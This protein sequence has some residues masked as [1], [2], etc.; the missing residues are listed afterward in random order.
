MG[1]QAIQQ[2]L[3]AHRRNSAYE[4]LQALPGQRVG[5]TTSSSV[6]EQLD[7]L[8][9]ACHRRPLAHRYRVLV[10]DGEQLL[11][12]HRA[13]LAGTQIRPD[14]SWTSTRP[15]TGEKSTSYGAFCL[16]GSL[17]APCAVSHRWR[18][19]RAGRVVRRPVLVVLLSFASMRRRTPLLLAVAA[20]GAW[21]GTAFAQPSAQF[22]TGHAEPDVVSMWWSV[23]GPVD[24]VRAWRQ[25]AGD[26]EDAPWVLVADTLMLNGSTAY[27]EDRDVQAG[28]RYDY[29]LGLV[30]EGVEHFSASVRMFLPQHAAA[31]AVRTVELVPDGLAIEWVTA[32]LG[33]VAVERRR[34][35]ALEWERLGNA[36]PVTSIVRWTDD[37]PTPGDSVEYQLVASGA[38]YGRH[39]FRVPEPRV[40]NVVL[41]A[42][43]RSVR[44]VFQALGKCADAVLERR[45][46]G[47]SE[48]ISVGYRTL[49][50]QLRCEFLDGPVFVGRTYHYRAGVDGSTERQW[51]PELTVTI[52][53]PPAFAARA[54]WNPATAQ[55]ALDV[56]M[57]LNATAGFVVFDAFGRRR[58]EHALRLVEGGHQLRFALPGLPPG[59]YYLQARVHDL[60]ATTRFALY[61]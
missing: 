53:P 35:P 5:A 59:V 38:A 15:G 24:L 22:L 1:S 54:A 34:I 40:E 23:T 10:R 61:R 45:E 43:S 57:P 48:W 55:L 26:A 14:E 9:V 3:E 31:A 27:V 16:F 4:A 2:A 47:A 58:W 18:T 56:N 25:D 41:D 44:L 17:A 49:D 28:A 13:G 36:F 32:S 51:G 60:T 6:A 8:V 33:E 7:E 29:R 19:D 50:A 20:L 30:L 39:R 52:P 21:A 12:V 46:A 42:D 11:V 37:E